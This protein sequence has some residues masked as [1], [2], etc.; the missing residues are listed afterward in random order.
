M[1]KFK[2]GDVVKFKPTV[3]PP[4]NSVYLYD[5]IIEIDEYYHVTALYEDGFNGNGWTYKKK[6]LEKEWVLYSPAMRKHG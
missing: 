2:V 3:V 5:L 6:A 1:D 4:Y